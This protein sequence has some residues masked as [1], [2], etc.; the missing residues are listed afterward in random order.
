MKNESLFA[1]V[2]GASSGIGKQMAYELASKG[3]NLLIISLPHQ[4]LNEVR[5]DIKAKYSVEVF[6]MEVDL[7]EMNGPKKVYEWVK[8]N[9]YNVDVLINNAGIAGTAVFDKSDD[10]YIDDRLLV[11][12]RA[13]VFLCRYFIPEMK[14]LT[15]AYILNVGSLS[16]Y[17]SIPFK[18]LYSATKAFVVNFSRAIR[19]ELTDTNISV[20]V[21]CPNGVRTNQGTHARIDAHG[22]KGKITSKSVEDV[23]RI[24][25]NGMYKKKFLIIPGMINWF[26]LFISRL[27]PRFLEQRILYN[28]FYKEVKVS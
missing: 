12:V 16:A 17:Y 1:L 21:V 4:N 2:S 6:S 19:T 5:E 27:L 11:N 25:L 7:S 14:L 15:E 22:A 9:Q 26:L 20:S 3:K 10:K 8:S 24:S 18:S 13:L 23:A 28:E